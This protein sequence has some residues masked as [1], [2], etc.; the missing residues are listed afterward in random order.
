MV[1][2]DFESSHPC[3]DLMRPMVKVIC[4][5]SYQT[6]FERLKCYWCFGYTDRCNACYGNA[7]YDTYE[8]W[9]PALKGTT[10]IHNSGYNFQVFSS[11]IFQHHF[12]IM[13]D[14]EGL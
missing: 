2:L 14:N 6:L 9:H 1:V 8:V 3:D 4:I 12:R 10:S 5:R 11:G 13:K 7:R